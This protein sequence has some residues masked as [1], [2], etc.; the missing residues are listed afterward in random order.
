MFIFSSLLWLLDM[1]LL[2]QTGPAGRM[3]LLFVF[4]YLFGFLLM[5]LMVRSCPSHWSRQRIY[6]YVFLFGILGRLFFLTYPVSN[7]VYRYIWEG[8]IQ[9]HGFNPY[10]AAPD[11]A[12]LAG[13]INGEMRGIW[14]QV[15][16]KSMSAIYPPLVTLFFRGL[17]AISPTPVMFKC[18]MIAVDLA[19]M[20]ALALILQLRKVQP[21]RLLLY[22]VNPF[23]LVY[24]AGEAHLDVI[25]A[26]FVAAGLYYLI[27]QRPVKGF[28]M[29]GAAVASKYL[30]IVILPF[31]VK[32]SNLYAWP[33]LAVAGLSLLP[34]A[35]DI[36]ALFSSLFVFG[37]SMHYNDGLAEIVRFFMG[38]WTPLFL[39]V[40]FML[41]LTII[42]LFEHEDL[43]SVYLAVGALLLLLP[44]LH[45]WYLLLMAPFIVLFPSRGWLLLTLAV[46]V[47]MPVLANAYRTGTFIEI[48]WLKLIE[49]GPFFLL[50]IYDVLSRRPAAGTHR[51]PDV[52]SVSVVIPTLNEAPQIEEVIVSAA[53]HQEVTEIII[54]DGGSADGTKNIA[55]SAGGEVLS[56]QPGRGHQI[57]AGIA[58][59]TGDVIIV[60]HADTMLRKGAVGAM[61]Q[62]L[63]RHP[64]IAG[65]AFAMRFT[66]QSAQ[67][68]LI[69]RLNNIRAEWFGISFG[70]QAQFFRRAA[71][72]RIGGFPEMMLMEDVELSLRMK[73]FGR[74]LFIRNGVNVSRR[75]WDQKGFKSNVRLIITL[76]LKYLVE[77]RFY[78]EQRVST[79]Y[80]T[81]Y[82]GKN[83]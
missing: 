75:R 43:R 42:Y 77:R 7:D 83:K 9:N 48:R 2:A 47:T 44:T 4:C 50:L 51:F 57:F 81:R 35:G 39:G 58:R 31:V 40:L 3:P 56:C 20:A 15:N 29:L 34:F 13:L 14:E 69:G 11:D 59:S 45:P 37:G 30:A 55:M 53:M 27:S 62:C 19:V 71:L 78:G 18:T 76:F 32:R 60:L 12:S 73:K 68:K 67:L 1:L 63:N 10:L 36:H 79:D 70:D 74:P 5:I 8:Y 46:I 16:H 22:G 24:V 17:S 82:Y 6:S 38:Q 65:G 25:Q 41:V 23:V 64:S 28:L 80:Y 72:D 54:A 66:G 33:A 26:A 21:G 52:Q 61:V 49:Y